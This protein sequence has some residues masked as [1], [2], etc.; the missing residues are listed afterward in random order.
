M[1]ANPRKA[2]SPLIIL[3]I[4]ILAVSAASLLIRF[5]QRE[6]PSLVIAAFRM[7][8][9]ALLVAP[10]CMK[11]FINEIKAASGSTRFLLGLSG[12][13]LA[14][15]F[16]SWITSL[17]YTSVASSV[18]LVTTAPLW[19][20]LLSPIFLNEKITRWILFGLAI[21][22]LG[23]IVVGISSACSIQTGKWACENMSEL[24]H[25]RALLGNALALAGAF[26][27]AGY[28]M[29][30]RKVRD[31]VS[32]STY[33]FAVYS[34]SAMVLLLLVCINGEKLTGY[35]PQTYLWLLGLALIP[36]I[37]GHSAFNWALKYLSAAYVSIALLGEP[38]GT[39]ILTMIF[40]RESPSA[41]ELVGGGL[42]L[43]GILVATRSQ[44]T[45]QVVG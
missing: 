38:I 26:L 45:K 15:H 37:I 40:L 28:L 18:V 31:K 2:T 6:A 24:F 4:G 11:T 41:L 9:A 3:F 17:E 8:I 21:S 27:S 10:F 5:A 13:F 42:I 35:S 7:T 32:L 44:R 39:V 23:S 43:L 30:G 22:L 19:V 29:V 12:L 16:A 1:I 36:Q 34:T 33:I 25:G 20:A 14:F